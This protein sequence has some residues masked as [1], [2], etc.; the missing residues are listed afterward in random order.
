[1]RTI[2]KVHNPDERLAMRLMGE[3]RT[4]QCLIRLLAA[5]SMLRTLLTRVLP[6][7]GSAGW[8]MTAACFLPGL[9]VYA[10]LWLSMRTTKAAV[11]QDMVRAVFGGFGVW[12]LAAVLPALLLLDGLSSMT[13]LITLFTEGIGTEGTQFTLAVLTGAVL[14]FCLHKQG[15]S[16]GVF[17]LRWIMLA[18]LAVMAWDWLGMAHSDGLFPVLGDGVPSLLAALRA[19][20]SL[21]WPLVLLLTAEPVHP[22][23]RLRPVLPVLLIVAGTVLLICLSLPHE[24]LVTHHDLSGSLLEMTLHLQPAVRMMAV[25]LVMLV[26]FLAIAGAAQLFTGLLTAPIGHDPVWL[27]YAFVALLVLSQLLPIRTLWSFLGLCGPWLLAP[28]AVLA[29]LA[30]PIALIQRRKA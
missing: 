14:A 25:C 29:V 24:L 30:L 23:V 13:A 12:V 22:G 16:R 6:L 10:L 20:I 5:V 18:A 28:L 26:M 2:V 7:A 1:M 11:L 21:A 3:R 4:A 8:W 9:A 19:G 17:F 15:L 27:P